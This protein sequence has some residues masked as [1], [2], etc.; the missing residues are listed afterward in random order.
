MPHST[1]MPEKMGSAAVSPA[2]AFEAGSFQ[3][4]TVIYTAGYF[5]IDDTGSIKVVH[6]F[7][8]DMGRPQFTDSTAPNYTTVEASNGAVLHVEYDMKRNIRPWD[9]TLYIK[10]VRGFLREEGVKLWV[11]GTQS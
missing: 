5:G 10:V 7:A 11:S 2:G 9:K 4:F 1:Y 3:E 6:R 8:S